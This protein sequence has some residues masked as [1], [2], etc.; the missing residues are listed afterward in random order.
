MNLRS[1]FLL[2][3]VLIASARDAYLELYENTSRDV[4]SV[5]P[6]YVIGAPAVSGWSK[7]LINDSAAK[8]WQNKTLSPLQK[9][10]SNRM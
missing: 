6:D 4:D 3:T 2:S 1:F 5:N 9:T 7:E 8:T 10:S